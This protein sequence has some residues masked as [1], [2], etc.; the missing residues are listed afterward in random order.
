MKRINPKELKTPSKAYSQGILVLNNSE[1]LYITGQLSQNFE[2]EVIYPDDPEKQTNI[3][4]QNISYILHEAGMDIANLAKI[5]IYYKN[6]EDID[7]ISEVRNKWL[8][9]VKPASLMI[10][11]SGFVKEGCCVEIEGI[12]IK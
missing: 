5:S 10:Q 1:T 7:K 3:I 12:A 4:F 2:G 11:V 6:K 9:N 8:E